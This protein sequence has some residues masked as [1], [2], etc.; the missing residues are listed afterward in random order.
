M[1]IA[2]IRQKSEDELN[3]ELLKLNKEA[4]NLRFQKAAGQMENTSLVRKLRRTIARIKTVL[5]QR[6]A[7]INVEVKAE[8]KKAPAK[9]TAKK[10]EAK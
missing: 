9:K 3:E 5:K 6:A 7:N 8:A 2:D 4:M 1:K 10:A